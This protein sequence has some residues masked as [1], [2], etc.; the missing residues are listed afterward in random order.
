ML[1]TGHSRWVDVTPR[2]TK[3]QASSKQTKTYI[4]YLKSAVICPRRQYPLAIEYCYAKFKKFIL[5]ISLF[6]WL[7]LKQKTII[8]RFTL[9]NS[10][11][12][13]HPPFCT[14]MGEEVMVKGNKHLYVSHVAHQVR[15]YSCF[16]MKQLRCT[17]TSYFHLLPPLPILPLLPR[18]GYWSTHGYSQY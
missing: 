1:N 18:M 9:S 14:V 10:S 7:Q 13:W 15:A 5:N 8:I 17:C 6:I 4:L 12:H 2:G 16:C 3:C 11:P